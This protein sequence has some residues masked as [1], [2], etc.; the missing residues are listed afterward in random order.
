MRELKPC[1][2]C[3]GKIIKIKFESSD[4]SSERHFLEC[5]SCYIEASYNT[6]IDSAIALWNERVPIND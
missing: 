3:G 6:C 2:F 5:Q 4:F 1:P